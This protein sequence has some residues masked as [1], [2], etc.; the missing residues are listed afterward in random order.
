MS[1][2]LQAALVALALLPS[3]AGS[4]QLALPSS[5]PSRPAP[6][7]EGPTPGSSLPTIEVVG[8]NGVDY[9][10]DFPASGPTTVLLFFVTSCPVCKRMVPE[11]NKAFEAKAEGLKVLGVSMDKPAPGFFDVVRFSFPVVV[12]RQP[13]QLA[14]DV[15]L[16]HVPLAVRVGP[17]GKVEDV[18]AGEVPAERVQKLF[19]PPAR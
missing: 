13:R 9:T 8:L 5:A 16:Q 3:L 15:N 17:G 10:V 14:R 6:G 2:R 4:A 7:Q 11:W 12:T 1:R 18:A 19:A